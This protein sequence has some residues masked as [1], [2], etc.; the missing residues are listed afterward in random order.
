MKKK[1]VLMKNIKH[2]FESIIIVNDD[3]DFSYYEDNG[4]YV[5]LTEVV[6]VNFTEL[7][8]KIILE[9][10]LIVIDK[11]ITKV[12]ADAEAALTALDG[13]KQELLAITEGV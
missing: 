9:K 11:Q 2:N 6:E 8:S 5:V 3:E 13:R 10:Q 12:K 1:I 4:D 7:D